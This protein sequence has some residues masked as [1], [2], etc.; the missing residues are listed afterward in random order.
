MKIK[1]IKIDFYLNRIRG[2]I[3]KDFTIIPYPNDQNII[4]KN[5]IKAVSNESKDNKDLIIGFEKYNNK[6][7]IEINLQNISF[8]YIKRYLEEIIAFKDD[9]ITDMSKAKIDID[10]EINQNDEKHVNIHKFH[11]IISYLYRQK[12]NFLKKP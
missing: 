5:L 2:Q 3:I 4:Y 7:Q 12:V 6:N 9:I 11:S 10:I 8:F 1:N